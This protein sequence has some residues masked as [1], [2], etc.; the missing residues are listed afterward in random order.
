MKNL[1]VT[2]TLLLF[3]F[4]AFSSSFTLAFPEAQGFGKY[5]QGG[6]GGQIYIVDSLADDAK[7]PAIG[8]LRHAIKQKGPR[9]IVFKVSG[10]IHLTAPLKI[11]HD[12]LT[13]AGQTSPKGIGVRGY[14]TVINAN[15]VIIRYVRFR[16]GTTKVE[17]DALSARNVSD[18][19][20]DHCSVSWG[21]DETASFYNVKRFTFQHSIVS[22][23]LNNAGHAKGV[24]GY[25]AIWGGSHASFLNNLIINHTSRTP[26]LNGYRLKPNY[27]QSEDFV[28]V[29]NNVIFNWSKKGAYGGENGRFNLTH[30]FFKQGTS[31]G[32]ERIF[33]FFEIKTKENLTKAHISQNYF[34]AKEKLTKA[35]LSGVKFA[36]NIVRTEHSSMLSAYALRP[37]DSF[38]WGVYQPD[39]AIHAYK[40]LILNKEVGA[41]RN[42]FGFFIDS[43]DQRLLNEVETGQSTFGNG[44]IDKELD[45][46]ESWPSYLAEFNL[47]QIPEDKNN[48]GIFDTWSLPN[49]EQQ[50]SE[51][52]IEQYINHLGA[53]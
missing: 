28:E 33:E 9:I 34:Y 44:I 50:S 43:I 27:P 37:A 42:F 52:L 46:I 29:I 47:A 21:I 15:Q 5:T 11:E 23:S 16:L 22:E 24:H 41:N 7:N 6:K 1:I 30:N 3:S 17:A 53:F 45:V 14:P 4:E 18:I 2:I 48:D 8:T 31:G 35:N 36:K 19:I 10:F 51:A 20:I 25:G 12:Y 38:S 13:I 39:S 32:P 26:R 40:K 49:N